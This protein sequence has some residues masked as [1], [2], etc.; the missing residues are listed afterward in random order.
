MT[1]NSPEEFRKL[2]MLVISKEI[3]TAVKELALK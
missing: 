3:K 1:Q 2:L